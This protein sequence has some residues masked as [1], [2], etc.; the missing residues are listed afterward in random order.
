[1]P[2]VPSSIMIFTFLIHFE[3]DSAVIINDTKSAEDKKRRRDII[4]RGDIHG[5][6]CFFGVEHQSTINQEMV[7]RCGIYEMTEYLKQL[8]NKKLK[9][10]VPQVMI[11]F[12]TG[13]KKWKRPLTLS[14]YLDIPEELKEY[15][16]DWKIKAV[17]VK[18]IDTSKIKDEQTR[19]HPRD[20]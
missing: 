20:V 18:E 17:D 14:D 8:K 16:N 4:V 10:L 3:N 2:V 19:S 9:G 12:Y 15:V 1:M 7:I 11:V 5:V 6:Y 13:P